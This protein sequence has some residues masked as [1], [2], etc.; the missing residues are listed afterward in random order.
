[1]APVLPVHVRTPVPP[2]HIQPVVQHPVLQS[3]LVAMAV[4][5]RPARVQI[6]VRLVHIVHQ[7]GARHNLRVPVSVRDVMVLL[8]QRHHVLHRVPKVPIQPVAHRHVQHVPQVNMV[9]PQD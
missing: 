4:Q 7:Q 6:N 9:Q 1:M 5:V 8:V 2:A 3:V